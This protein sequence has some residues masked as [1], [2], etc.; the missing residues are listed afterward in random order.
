MSENIHEKEIYCGNCGAKQSSN[1][2]FCGN[3]GARLKLPET[4]ESSPVHVEKALDKTKDAIE[5][6]F[7]ET[8]LNPPTTSNSEA[9]DT[10][11]QEIP[12][13]LTPQA[14][15]GNN[16]ARKKPI[17]FV[18]VAL[19]PVAVVLMI[20]L[21]NSRTTKQSP[22][23]DTTTQDTPKSIPAI[24][25]PSAKEEQEFRLGSYIL[26]FP[27]SWEINYDEDGELFIQGYDEDTLFLGILVRSSDSLAG[28]DIVG[29]ED[30]ILNIFAEELKKEMNPEDG[31]QH[32]GDGELLANDL[33]LKYIDY[34]M[35]MNA[36]DYVG[37]GYLFI[38]HGD[39]RLHMLLCTWLNAEKY[40]CSKTLENIMQSMTYQPTAEQIT[41]QENQQQA[42]AQSEII[43]QED[44]PS[45]YAEAL[46]EALTYSELMNMSKKGIYDQLTSEWDGF[47]AEA[48]Q[49][50]V[51]HVNVDWNANALKKAE[52]YSSTLNMS[53]RELYNQLVSEYGEQF[54][55]SE[56]Q[57][58]MDNIQADWNENALKRAEMY[59]SM[60]YMSKQGIYDQL[61]SEY[62]DQFEISEA[63]YAI[64]HLNN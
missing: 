2:T 16:T 4:N 35:E 1:A 28:Y 24:K 6:I 12:S 62:G 63:Q 10:N 48:A 61:I 21:G 8:G 56:A 46:R 59:S 53:K 58:A 37:R 19:L 15:T 44:V 20:I 39:Q 60:M 11:W 38:D 33:K 27:A 52:S 7:A 5:Q 31:Y 13:T 25:R 29:M 43:V 41:A 57:Y 51:D 54:E 26:K 23:A 9:N 40:D 32:Q 55:P 45:E 17:W 50:A 14:K 22:A 47:S 30:D 34:T 3:C 49:Y 42:E 64:D 36:V 18:F